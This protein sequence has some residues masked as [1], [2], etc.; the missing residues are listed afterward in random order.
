MLQAV[1]AV[2]VVLVGVRGEAVGAVLVGVRG[3]AVG[4]VGM[5]QRRGD[6]KPRHSS[7]NTLIWVFSPGSV[8][9]TSSSNKHHFTKMQSFCTSLICDASCPDL[10]K[11]TLFFN[12]NDR[13]D[14][15]T[16]GFF[17]NSEF[18][19]SDFVKYTESTCIQNSMYSQ[20]HVCAL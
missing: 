18:V 20:F 14:Y 8:P 10:A 17:V 1:G 3:E 12:K 6:V 5:G 7:T 11:V 19:D 9:G 13:D 4:A 16:W 2:G 15:L